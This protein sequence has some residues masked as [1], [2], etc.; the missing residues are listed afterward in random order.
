VYAVIGHG[1]KAALS[2]PAP[3]LIPSPRTSGKRDLTN[4]PQHSYLNR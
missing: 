2:R 4:V 1:D 3:G